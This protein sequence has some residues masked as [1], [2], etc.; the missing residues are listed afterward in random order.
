MPEPIVRY[1]RFIRPFT[2]LVP[3]LGMVC[4]ALMGLSVDPKGVS[5]WSPGGE[6]I[7]LRILAGAVLAASLNAFSNGLN[8]IC[9]LEIDRVNKPHRLLPSGRISMPEAWGLS[10][11]FLVVALLLAIWINLQCFL[12]VLGGAL[13]TC[14]YSAPPFRT[15]SRGIWANL[16]IAVVRGTLLPVAGWSTVKHVLQPEPWVLGAILGVYFL[17]AVTTKDFSDVEGDRRGGCRTL[18]VIYGVHRSIRIIAPFFI[19]PFLALIPGAVFGLL[20]GQPALLAGLGLILAGWGGW[21]ILLLVRSSQEWEGS[22]DWE[23]HPSWRQMYLLTLTA[24]VGL[25][26][27]YLL[28]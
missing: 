14:L 12:V 18:P 7:I 6:E 13:G 10:L 9:D 8:Q 21:I 16:T 27:A 19:L 1:F 28:R 3:A 4:G 20:S 17:G 15:K 5:D 26:L 11:V 22:M 23:N 24:Q 25:V 2:L